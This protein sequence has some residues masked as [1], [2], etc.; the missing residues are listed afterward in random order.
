MG[1][2]DDGDYYSTDPRGDWLDDVAYRL[3][4]TDLSSLAGMQ[5]LVTYPIGFAFD[6]S[7]LQETADNGGG[8]YIG[9]MSADALEAA[10]NAVI[11]DA[12]SRSG[13]F[14][15]P[16]V[17]ASRTGSGD[18]LLRAWFEP[19][20]SEPFWAGHLEA[21]RLAP[22]GQIL[23]QNGDAATDPTG[24]FDPNAVPYWDAGEELKTNTSREMFTTKAG[25]PFDF[26]KTSITAGDSDLTAAEIP[27]YPNYDSPAVD[28]TTVEDL[29]D[30]IVDYIRGKDAFDE[31]D[32][33]DGDCVERWVAIFGGGYGM[34]GTPTAQATSAIRAMGRSR[35]RASPSSSSP[36]T[37]ET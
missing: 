19:K 7:L 9:A 24:M 22:D 8:I 37:T 29:R 33:G 32:D 25:G 4:R 28:I 17:P 20:I 11:I 15:A 6:A 14:T 13:S 26:K 36:S 10:L 23:D 12:L 18:M 21:Y 16:A 1:G 27:F 31:D 5:N 2:R 35:R 34:T 30:A 3:Y